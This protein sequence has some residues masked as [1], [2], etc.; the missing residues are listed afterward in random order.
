MEVISTDHAP[1]SAEEKALPMEKAP[2]GIVG[3]ETSAALTYTALVDSK[4]ISPLD[5]ARKMSYTPA[6]ILGI[7]KGDISVGRIADI[8]I[9]NPNETYSIDSSTFVSKGHNTPYDGYPVKG[10]VITTIVSGKTVYEYK[11][12]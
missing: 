2:F 7:E 8:V 9:F 12:N 4:V 3:L 6:K 1:H 10:R 5:M 11:N